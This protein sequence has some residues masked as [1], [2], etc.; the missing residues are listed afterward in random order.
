MPDKNRL[1]V[2]KKLL[3]QLP[4]LRLKLL[5]RLCRYL[6]LV[7]L[8]ED[9]NLMSVDNIAIVMA[10]NILRSE[11]LSLDQISEAHL[12]INVVSYFINRYEELLASSEDLLELDLKEDENEDISDNFENTQLI[13]EPLTIQVNPDDVKSDTNEGTEQIE[14]PKSPLRDSRRRRYTNALEWLI[15][16][17]E[18]GTIDE[19]M[20]EE[21]EEKVKKHRSKKSQDAAK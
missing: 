7:S 6:R 21:K 2:V 13:K 9:A 20:S 5:E 3:N 14:I 4:P 18:D 15:A 16:V 12:T 19:M 10:P 11:C 8:H 17:Q 1:D